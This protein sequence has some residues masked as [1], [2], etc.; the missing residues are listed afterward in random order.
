VADLEALPPASRREWPSATFPGQETKGHI[1]AEKAP[2]GL[3]VGFRSSDPLPDAVALG[4]GKGCRYGQERFADAIGHHFPDRRRK[5]VRLWFECKVGG[6]AV[7]RPP[8]AS[9]PEGRPKRPETIEAR[10]VVADVKAAARELTL[11]AI[12][13]LK[14]AMADQKA[15]WAAKIAAAIAVLDRG[16]AS[17]R[18]QSTRM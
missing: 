15:P 7:L 16:W 5:A 9:N 11:D 12:E 4:L 18:K 10:R 2:P 3:L 8:L 14:S 6:R 13:T 1:P 17:Q